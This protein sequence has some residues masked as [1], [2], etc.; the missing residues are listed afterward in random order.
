[1]NVF[2]LELDDSAILFDEI[3]AVTVAADTQAQS[4]VWVILKGVEEPVIFTRSTMEEARQ[5]RKTITAQWNTFLQQKQQQREQSR[6]RFGGASR[7]TQSSPPPLQ[8]H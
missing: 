8:Q 4:E 1:M 7:H 2:V 6:M 5:L 3:A